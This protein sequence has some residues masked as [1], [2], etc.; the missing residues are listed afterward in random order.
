[1]D[2]DA[3][4]VE[5]KYVKV[6][7]LR[8]PWDRHPERACAVRYPSCTVW[9]DKNL[10]NMDYIHIRYDMMTRLKFKKTG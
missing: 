1:M 10:A 9:L 8:N 2:F 7:D 3:S 6:V 4:P 5:K